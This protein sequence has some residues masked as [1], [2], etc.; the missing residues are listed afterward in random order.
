M[1][2]DERND[3][4][5]NTA[6]TEPEGSDQ[7]ELDLHVEEFHIDPKLVKMW[8]KIPAAEPINF[9]GRRASFD[10]LY[11]AIDGLIATQVALFSAVIDLKTGNDSSYYANIE[12]TGNGIIKALNHLRHFQTMVMQDATGVELDADARVVGGSDDDQE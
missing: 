8:F 2:D 9:E 6:M 11:S 5:S 3:N 12:E 7:G 10:A 1:S 4:E